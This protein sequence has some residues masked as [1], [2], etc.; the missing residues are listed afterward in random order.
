MPPSPI[1]PLEMHVHRR[2]RDRYQ[3]DELFLT[4]RDHVIFPTFHAARLFAAKLNARR[5]LVRFPEQAASAGE[6]NALGL[7]V[8]ILHYVVALYRQQLQPGVIERAAAW[9]DEDPGREAVDTVLRRFVAELPPHAV[10]RRQADAPAFLAGE[11][12]GVPHRLVLLEELL[13]LWLE[14]VNPAFSPFLDLFDDAE[15]ERAT[16]YRRLWPR[17]HEFFAA[18]PPFGPDRQSLLDMLRAPALAVPHS[19]A[20]Q[21]EYIRERWGHLLGDRLWKLLSGLD[22]LREEQRRRAFVKGTADVWRFDGGLAGG[23]GVEAERYSPDR[24]WMPRLVLIAKSVHV[25]LDQLSR[26]HGRTIARLDQIPD[27][28]L[29]RLARWGFTGLWLIGVWE[30]SRASQRIKQMCGNPEAVASAY[31]LYDYEIAADLG[32]EAAF[33]ELRERAWRRGIR[34]AGDMVP[35]H[36]GIDGRWV[37]EH[38]DWFIGLDHSPFPAYRFGRADLSSD[39][40]VGLY[41][42]DHYYERSDAAVVFQRVD[43]ATGSVRYIYHGNDGTSMPWNDTAQLD[44]L[45]A[46]VREAVVQTILRVTRLFPIIRF[47]A[48]MTLAKRHYQRLWFPAPGTGGDIPSRAGHGL[49]REQFDAAMP[50]EFWREVVERCAAEAPDTLLLAEAFWLMEGYFVRTLG[51]HRVYNSAFMNMLKMEDNAQYR[52]TV[53]NVLEFDPEILKRFVNFM[54]NPDEE[55]AVAQF[56]KGDKYFGVCLLLATMPGLPMFGHGQIEGLTEKYGMEYRR[57][58][59]QED[60]D[61]ELVRRHEAEICPLLHRRRLFA[62]V[63]SFRFYDLRQP[64]GAVNENVFA[65]SNRDGGER[66]L[67]VFHNRYENARG[68]I[69][70]AVPFAA[71]TGR[72]EERALAHGSLC[73]GLGLTPGPGRFCAFRD[74][75]DGLEYLRPVDELAAQGL[76]V[77]LGAYQRHAFLDWRE[78]VDGP[79]QPYG[80]LCAWLGGRGVPSLDQALR[81]TFLQPLLA[82]L[83]ELLEPELVAAL[84]GAAAPSQLPSPAA[85]G[86][87]AAPADAA[88]PAAPTT[89]PRQRRQPSTPPPPAAPAPSPAALAAGE[90]RLRRFLDQA[91]RLCAGTAEI[92]RLAAQWRREIA[93]AGGLLAEPAA[94]AT[95]AGATPAGARKRAADTRTALRGAA[96]EALAADP[97][98][99]P[100]LAAWLAVHAVG[101]LDADGDAAARARSRLDEWLLGKVAADAV[102]GHGLDDAAADRAVLLLRLLVTHRDW[103]DRS[104]PYRLCTDLLRDED[105]RRWLGV[106]RWQGVLYLRQEAWTELLGWLAVVALVR[107]AAVEVAGPSAT[108]GEPA[109]AAAPMPAAARLAAGATTLARLREAGESSGWQVEQLL[110]L[111]G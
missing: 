11:R 6:L 20:G 90:E 58:Y 19:L 108:A 7:I 17:L 2:A 102:R 69:R 91:Q 78:V 21:L 43:R 104:D 39:P 76:Y 37:I 64:D 56:G 12:E 49:T 14:N 9:L 22:L 79:G 41:I 10:W 67:V 103:L 26:W 59:W 73:Q 83:R 87:A 31:S 84:L 97:S 110:L 50:V 52:A 33:H 34:M 74:Q 92:E 98:A 47:D 60:P 23:E 81:Q 105:G 46:D 1:V 15:L 35:N 86:A 36:V 109:A 42:D 45:R 30:R 93:A 63:E 72:G 95:E 94:P 82:P 100:T 99:R 66:A 61:P 89:R 111:V 88:A 101:E 62:G 57:A 80:Q 18:Q 65:L 68:W 16:P 32:G 77:E 53:R 55:T 44:Y 107:S 106:N 48:A 3:I 54:N 75:I 96:T 28:E 25:W 5:D 8:E 27:A 51:M 13:M 38:P 4:Q 29:D 70:D 24:D 85:P 71:R 40:R